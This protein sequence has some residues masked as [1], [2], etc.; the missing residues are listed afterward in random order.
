MQIC[1]HRF[2]FLGFFCTL[3]NLS[4][5]KLQIGFES[6]FRFPCFLSRNSV[7]LLPHPVP[8][9]QL[10]LLIHLLLLFFSS[11][12]SSSSSSFSSFSSSSFFYFFSFPPPPPSQIDW[13]DSFPALCMHRHAWPL[14][15]LVEFVG[16]RFTVDGLLVK[17]AL[18]RRLGAY[19]WRSPVASI[20]YHPSNHTIVGHYAPLQAGRWRVAVDVQHLY[21][22]AQHVTLRVAS[23]DGDSALV[24]HQ[25]G[26]QAS[27][28]ASTASAGLQF[29]IQVHL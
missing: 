13:T 14:V 2:F 12:F 22:D 10:H 7:P 19:A 5:E 17:P 29:Q 18:P 20:T 4:D 25:F 8:S 26:S 24:S 11:S 21:P 28:A 15:T 3:S 23:M 27:V 1:M 6:S 9:F 16:L